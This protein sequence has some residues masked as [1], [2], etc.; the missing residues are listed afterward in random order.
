[1]LI[2][3]LRSLEQGEGKNAASLMVAE[4]YVDAF[5]KLARTSNTLIL[6]ANVGDVSSLVGQAMSVYTT[7]SKQNQSVAEKNAQ[8]TATN[9][10]A[11]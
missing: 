6:P 5:D 11:E 8:P 7:I 3:K 10:N 2:C 4:K 9:H 1:M